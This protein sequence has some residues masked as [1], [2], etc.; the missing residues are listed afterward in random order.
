MKRTCDRCG[1][2]DDERWMKRLNNGRSVK[3]LCYEC[4]KKAQQEVIG[5]EVRSQKQCRKKTRMQ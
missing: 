2:E 4:D 5:S 3:W 1:A